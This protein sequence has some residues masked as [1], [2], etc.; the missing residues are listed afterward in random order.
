[1]RLKNFLMP[2]NVRPNPQYIEDAYL[3]RFFGPCSIFS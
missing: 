3:Y 1:M 2:S